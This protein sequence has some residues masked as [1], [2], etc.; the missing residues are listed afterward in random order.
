[1][2]RAGMREAYGHEHLVFELG[3]DEFRRV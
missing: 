1:M 2:R 3:R